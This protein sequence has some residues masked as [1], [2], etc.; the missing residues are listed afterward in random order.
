MHPTRNTL[1]NQERA[2]FT[3]DGACSYT[4]IGKSKIYEFMRDG[5]LPFKQLGK[6][7][8]LR[9]EDLDRLIAITP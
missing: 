8:L 9:R 6:R 3:V 4:S 5:E 7:R 1:Q 2:A